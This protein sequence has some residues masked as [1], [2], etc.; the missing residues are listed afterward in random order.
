[1]L[2]IYHSC[3]TQEQEIFSAGAI[4]GG[5]GDG[6]APF[7]MFLVNSDVQFGMV[8]QSAGKPVGEITIFGLEIR[9]HIGS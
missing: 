5:Y 6:C 9:F 8:H 4:H 3:C 7:V 1:M 2:H